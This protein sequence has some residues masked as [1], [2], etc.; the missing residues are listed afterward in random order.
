MYVCMYVCVYVSAISGCGLSRSHALTIEIN[1]DFDWIVLLLN[2][3]AFQQVD[4]DL[5]ARS[6]K[7]VDK[8]L[9]SAIGIFRA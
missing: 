6:A 2:K 8:E 4:K 9:F 3:A 7:Q 1:I 5:F